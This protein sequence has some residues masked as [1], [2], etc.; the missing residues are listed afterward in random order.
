MTGDHVA[1]QVHDYYIDGL[2]DRSIG[3]ARD[4][5]PFVLEVGDVATARFLH[6]TISCALLELGLYDEAAGEAYLLL[7][8]IEDSVIEQ[9]RLVGTYKNE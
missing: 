4:T 3:L 5:L 6:Y 8:R 2:S 1:E 9:A 7:S